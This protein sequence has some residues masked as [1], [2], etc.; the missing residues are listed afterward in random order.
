MRKKVYLKPCTDLSINSNDVESLCIKIHHKKNKNILLSV[1][2]RPPDEDI[3]VF[4]KFCENLLS[5]ND[6]K[7]KKKKNNCW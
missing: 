5:A 2:Y 4:K 1:M 3:I 6:K 7:S